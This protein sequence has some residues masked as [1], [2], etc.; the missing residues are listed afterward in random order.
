MLFCGSFCFSLGLNRTAQSYINRLYLFQI[1]VQRLGARVAVREDLARVLR[2][3][4]VP[5]LAGQVPDPVAA[6]AGGLRAAVGARRAAPPVAGARPAQRAA[7]ARAGVARP[8]GA[9]HRHGA[10]LRVVPG[11][12]RPAPPCPSPRTSS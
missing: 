10:G 1:P 2:G 4:R 3:A 5:V 11:C 12:P 6:A 7:A 8:P 9:R